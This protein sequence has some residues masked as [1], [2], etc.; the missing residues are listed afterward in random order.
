MNPTMMKQ[1]KRLAIMYSGQPRNMEACIKNHSYAI[2]KANPHWDIDIFVHFLYDEDAFRKENIPEWDEK[3][4][5][6]AKR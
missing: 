2:H 6:M 5:R 1:K 4:R 3:K